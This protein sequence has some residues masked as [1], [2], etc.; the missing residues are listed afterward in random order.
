MTFECVEAGKDDAQLM[1]DLIAEVWRQMDHKEW[2]AVEDLDYIS[3]L[4]EAGKALAWKMVETESG[5]VAGVYFA[6]V[7]GIDA[8][9]LGYDIGLTGEELLKV[10]HMDIAAVLSRYR[11]NRL[12]QRMT[13][14]AEE[15]LVEKGYTYLMCTI[16]PENSFS[17]QTMER[18]GYKLVKQAYKYGGL[19][20]NIYLKRF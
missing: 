3:G 1:A 13:D 12:Q 10:A 5:E 6:V 8:D 11:G 7:P 4:M 18:R 16:H 17:Y 2:F 20:R 9:N 15:R 19:L 14:E